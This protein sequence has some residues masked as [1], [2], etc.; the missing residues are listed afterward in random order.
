MTTE[1]WLT[2]SAVAVILLAAAVPLLDRL[3]DA[4]IMR[5]DV[6]AGTKSWRLRAAVRR[7]ED[8]PLSMGAGLDEARV[9]DV[10]ATPRARDN[11]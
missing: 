8:P 3:T 4:P 5:R 2:I 7:H 1:M 9:G 6:N 11:R 10:V